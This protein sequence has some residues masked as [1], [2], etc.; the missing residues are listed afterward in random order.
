MWLAAS[1]ASPTHAQAPAGAAP[2]PSVIV[3]LARKRNVA[4]QSVFTGRVQAIDKVTIRARVAGFI[5]KRGFE[6]GT[7]VDEGQLLFQLEKEP[8][9][10]ALALAEANHANAQAALELA[11]A[12]YNRTKPLA[13]RGTSSQAALD[14]AVSQLDQAKAAIKAQE[15]NVQTAKLNLGYTEI[16]SPLAGAAGRATY[17]VGEYVGPSSDPLVTIVRQD[18]IYV[19]FPV[20]QRIFLQVRREGVSKESVVVRLKLPDGTM[21]DQDGTI[22]FSDVE[23]NPQTDTVTV[24]ATFPNPKR[25]LVDQQIVGVQVEAREPEERLVISQSA[26]ILDQ[27]GAYVLVVDKDNKVEQRRVKLGDQ[28]GPEII[29]QEGLK[30][31]DRV[32]VSGQQKVRPGIAVDAQVATDTLT[33]TSPATP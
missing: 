25:L 21:Y 17:S 24:R 8:Y 2:P 7:E 19:A 16:R 26:V 27:Q 31:G 29:V 32:I 23:T 3:E 12:T 13:E 22:A 10:A 14:Q 4:D 20:P 5:K 1:L 30:E 11:E 28:R 6:E 18:P 33:S 15:A 9:E